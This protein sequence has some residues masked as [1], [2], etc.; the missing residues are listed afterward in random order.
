MSKAEHQYRKR[1]IPEEIIRLTKLMEA[2]RIRVKVG[3]FMTTLYEEEEAGEKN[4]MLKQKKLHDDHYNAVI[5]YIETKIAAWTQFINY[6]KDE[7][8]LDRI[9]ETM[10]DW[11]QK[12]WLYLGQE[13]INAESKNAIEEF[14]M[15]K[16]LLTRIPNKP[17]KPTRRGGKKHKKNKQSE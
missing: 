14:H 11:L 1:N 4:K 16:T 15:F 7:N 6:E 17:K 12:G 9:N 8:I 3:D 10:D 13:N 5:L 2:A